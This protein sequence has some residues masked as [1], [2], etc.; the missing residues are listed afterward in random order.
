MTIFVGG[1]GFV[2]VPGVLPN[3]N[4]GQVRF[5][6]LRNRPS[7]LLFLTEP[8]SLAAKR[9]NPRYR[10][11][12]DLIN[13]RCDL[14]YGSSRIRTIIPNS[15]RTLISLTDEEMTNVMH[16]LVPGSTAPL[17]PDSFY[18]DVWAPL[19]Q[20]MNLISTGAEWRNP[21]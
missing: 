6:L 12:D 11:R 15:V 20:S 3:G 4:E 8:V 18:L 9:D 13:I 19:G 2:A 10:L 1:L 7:Y 16:F 5:N 17:A 14:H 21:P